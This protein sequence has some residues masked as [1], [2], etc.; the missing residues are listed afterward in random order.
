MVLYYDQRGKMPR[1]TGFGI[2][3]LNTAGEDVTTNLIQEAMT[4][5]NTVVFD[6]ESEPLDGDIVL[7]EIDF[8]NYRIRQFRRIKFKGSDFI[9]ES[10]VEKP[11]AK[12]KWLKDMEGRIIG[13]V[14]QIRGGYPNPAGEHR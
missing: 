5:G 10:D 8:P 9:F 13:K 4:A 3:L 2:S 11:I 12:S 1:W 6:Y 7:A 14:V